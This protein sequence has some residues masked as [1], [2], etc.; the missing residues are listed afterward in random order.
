MV[1]N[2]RLVFKVMKTIQQIGHCINQ[3]DIIYYVS[4]KDGTYAIHKTCIK[5]KSVQ[6]DNGFHTG[7]SNSVYRCEDGYAF[8]TSSLFFPVF[9]ARIQVVDYIGNQLNAEIQST[10]VY[11]RNAQEH[12]LRLRC[13]IKVYQKYQI[14]DETE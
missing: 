3:G 5:E 4:F 14:N 2:G 10:E 6:R 7:I 9:H 12:L 11:L 13:T 8:E 1:Y